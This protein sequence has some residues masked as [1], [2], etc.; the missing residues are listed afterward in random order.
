MTN[1]RVVV[2]N[3][4][5]LD[6]GMIHRHMYVGFQPFFLKELKGHVVLHFQTTFEKYLQ[7]YVTHIS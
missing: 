7:K 6:H 3:I 4:F 5:I 1:L 2:H